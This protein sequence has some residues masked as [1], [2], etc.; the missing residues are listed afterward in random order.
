VVAGGAI[1]GV[2]GGGTLAQAAAQQPRKVVA[3]HRLTPRDRSLHVARRL[4]YGVTPEVLGEIRDGGIDAWLQ[5]QLDPGTIPDGRVEHYLKRYPLLGLGPADVGGQMNYGSWD[6]MIQT[7]KA[8]IVRAVWSRRQVY[9]LMVDLWWNHFNI[10][11]PNSDVWNMIGA[12][13]T[14]IR[15]HALGKFSDLLHAMSRSP[16]LL[17]SL[18]APVSSGSNP[19]QNYARELLELHTV[20]VDGGYDQN[21]VDQASLLLTG[22]G[23]GS[24]GA[25]FAYNAGDHYVGPVSIMGF[26]AANPSAAGGLPVIN[27]YVD[28]LAHHKST[29][30][31]IASKLATRFVSDAPSAALIDRLAHV[32]LTNDTAIVPV[33]WELFHSPEFYASTGA[34]VRRPLEDVAA[35]LRVLAFGLAN[36][37]TAD[38][39]DLYF[40][41]EI[42]GHQPMG[43]PQPNGYPDV[44]ASWRSASFLQEAWGIHIRLAGGWW[45]QTLTSPGI[46]KLI[47]NPAETTTAGTVVDELCA[48][49][50]FQSVLPEHRTVFLQFLG[51]AESDPIGSDGLDNVWMLAKVILDSP[52]WTVR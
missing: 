42:M 16:A 48:R 9:E 44:A 4:T 12:H 17:T 37:E 5:A 10:T 35:S 29:A 27:R 32:Y 3:N 8:R 50:L 22:L 25:T 24:D 18:S 51:K 45:T 6:Q 11:V 49:L 34:K 1:A 31:H 38:L 46:V 14:Q 26:H 52:Y 15:R 21:D 2:V 19:N 47:G 13:E 36:D 20:G 41:L 40:A 30:Q 23:L 39:D 7:Q 33:L 43:W 28:Y